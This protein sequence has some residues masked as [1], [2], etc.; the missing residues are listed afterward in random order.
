[1]YELSSAVSRDT[2]RLVRAPT[3]AK[4]FDGRVSRLVSSRYLMNVADAVAAGG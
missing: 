1:M 4:T 2:H 3:P